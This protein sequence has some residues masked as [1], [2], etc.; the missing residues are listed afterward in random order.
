MKKD[1]IPRIQVH[2]LT[3]RHEEVLAVDA[4]SF[5]VKNGEFFSILGP[6]G[7]GKTTTLR[8]IAG[9]VAPDK[10]DVLIDGRS[11]N[12]LAPHRRPVNTVFQHYALFPHMSVRNNIAFGLKMQGV[13]RQEMERRVE[14]TLDIVKLPEK[15]NRMPSELSGGEQQRVAL[16]RALINRPAVVLLDEPM[17]ALDQQ[18][19]LDM[20]REL[21]MIQAHVGITCICVTHHQSEALLMSDRVAVMKDGRLMQIG[22]PEE[23]YE[24]PQ[25]AFVAQ[26]IG[27]SNSVEG[28]IIGTHQSQ[29]YSMFQS[30]GMKPIY[31]PPIEEDMKGRRAILVLRPERLTL[32]R[33]PPGQPSQNSLE[34]Q[35]E[36]ALYLGEE[37]QYVLSV[38][39][40]VSWTVRDVSQQDRDSRFR[41]G[42]KA[43]MSW[44]IQ[45]SLIFPA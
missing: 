38:A 35:V 32:S 12:G 36:Q 39:P 44:N 14:E 28:E 5:E 33:Q 41:P 23:L 22:E 20:Q 13:A 25:N 15:A 43:F 40:R 8:L 10:G 42:E 17:G 2:G 18:L 9:L 34:V 21:K 3:K 16:A 6:S 1:L 30:V 24:K 19:R 31:L 4:L 29:P 7:S 11:V 37:I 26:F 27:Q 45:H